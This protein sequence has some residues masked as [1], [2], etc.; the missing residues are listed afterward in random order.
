MKAGISILAL[1]FTMKMMQLS[2]GVV[3]RK[4]ILKQNP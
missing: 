3:L 1:L 4:P 2:N